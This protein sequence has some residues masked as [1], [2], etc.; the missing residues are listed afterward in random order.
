MRKPVGQVEN[1]PYHSTAES[2]KSWCV[3]ENQKNSNFENRESRS[4]LYSDVVSVKRG[5]KQQNMYM[6]YVMYVR[7]VVIRSNLLLG[8]S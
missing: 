8:K 7:Y 5:L 2:D 1:A 3:S 4:T 6:L